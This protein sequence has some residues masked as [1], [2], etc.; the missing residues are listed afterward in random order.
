V[1]SPRALGHGALYGPPAK[2]IPWWGVAAAV[3]GPVLLIGGYLLAS[4]LQPPW[5]SP[6]RNT[7]SQLAAQGATD[8]W[9]MTSAIAGLGFCYL[10]AALALNPARLLGRVVLV[11]G[12][13]ATVW[14]AAFRQ[15]ARGYS[16]P[17][18][19]AVI[20]AALTLCTWPLFAS[21]QR[22]WAPL[23]RRGPSVAAVAFLLGL[24][25]WYALESRGV[26]L[27]LAERFAASAPPIWILAVVVTTRRG[28]LSRPAS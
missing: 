1:P 24:A 25:L 9:L 6:V 7:I 5:Y 4:A 8:A 21:S 20:V 26:L 17:H 3:A 23:L 28:A 2:A 22:H 13:A 11:V 10:L 27:G 18:E 15:P 16:V 12:A 19:L 14:I